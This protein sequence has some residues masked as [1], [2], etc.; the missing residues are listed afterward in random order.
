[1]LGAVV[2]PLVV[3][4]S[5]CTKEVGRGW[6]PSTPETTNHTGRIISLWNGSWIAALI[7]G[8]VVWGLMLWVVVAY[9][10][11]KDDAQLPPQVRYNIP[12]EIL[13]TVVPLMAIGAL[14]YHT[15]VIQ[16]E[17][18]DT[19]K[20]PDVTINV[21]G[22]QWSWDFVYPDGAGGLVYEAGLQGE[23]DGQP[24]VEAKLPTLYLPKDK[25]IEF[26]LTSRDVIHSF[27][28]PSFLYKLDVIPGLENRFQV[29]PQREGFFKGKCAE[30]CGE[31]HS[32][33]LFNVKVVSQEVY[34]D[35]I[36][37]LKAA[38]QTGDL[39]VNLGRSKT[40]VGGAVPGNPNLGNPA[41]T[42]SN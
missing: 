36:A 26:V 4:L 39:G 42:G 30:L 8:V 17:I 18:T 14:F 40:P 23:L 9:R 5:G 41:A 10:R 33:M 20:T 31:Y 24:G 15:A 7:V 16:G 37:A 12:L 6:L 21:I 34:D 25:N 28:I 2:A 13:Y 19:S 3:L 22:K 11:R 27:W 32:A 29:V 1:M 38:G 35:H